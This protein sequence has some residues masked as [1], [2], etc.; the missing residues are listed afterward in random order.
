[1]IFELQLTIY[2][3]RVIQLIIFFL[4][5]ITF[6]KVIITYTHNIL[7]NLKN[8]INFN[9]HH[10]IFRSLNPYF[11]AHMLTTTRTH[12]LSLSHSLPMFL[13][14]TLY[15]VQFPSYFS[16][17]NFGI[18]KCSS[19]KYNVRFETYFI[20]SYWSVN[21][22]VNSKVIKIVNFSLAVSL[23]LSLSKLSKRLG[24]NT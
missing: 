22:P 21:T 11:I 10:R 6:G 23:F 24:L 14:F 9:S 15:L 17:W 3:N 1:M 4:N 20:A 12:S 2:F 16:H 7:D 18:G 13:S 8:N 19:L 5:A